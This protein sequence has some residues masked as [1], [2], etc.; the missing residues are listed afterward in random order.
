MK[1]DIRE[2]L[3]RRKNIADSGPGVFVTIRTSAGTSFI[4]I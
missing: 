3:E 4:E 1:P 2:E